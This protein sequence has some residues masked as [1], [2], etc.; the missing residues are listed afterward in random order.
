MLSSKSNRIAIYVS[1]SLIVLL[2][3]FAI[4]RDNADDIA[5]GAANAMLENHSVE[6]VVVSKEY[7]YLKTKDDLF[8][9]ATSQV[10][11]KMFVDYKV[12]VSA[13]KDILL[14]I[15]F[16]VLFLGLGSLLLRFYQKKGDIS[17]SSSGI[18]LG[19]SNSESPEMNSKI[20]ST[21]SDV[22]FDDIGGISDVK[23]EL[24][25]IIDFMKNP[26]R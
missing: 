18:S 7:V 25:E 20:E 9:I 19:S 1:A 22:T 13:K 6:K 26:K 16:A 11:P 8:R 15:L 17:I 3:I 24:E 2:I 14:Y 10:T 5:L 4:V 23:I 21:K 12:E